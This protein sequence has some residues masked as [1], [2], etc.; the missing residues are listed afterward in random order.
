MLKLPEMNSKTTILVL[1]FLSA[2][3][4]GAILGLPYF[5][6]GLATPQY[7]STMN[8]DNDG[9]N[10]GEPLPWT[11]GGSLSET[12]KKCKEACTKFGESCAGFTQDSDLKQCTLKSTKGND[13]PANKISSFW[14]SVAA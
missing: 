14:R 7:E 1:A 2:I 4:I 5:K 8:M 13:V 9:A 10:L 11:E 6:E 3:L 12:L